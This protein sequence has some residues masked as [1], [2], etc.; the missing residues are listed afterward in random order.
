[1][2]H[3]YAFPR[4]ENCQVEPRDIPCTILRGGYNNRSYEDADAWRLFLCGKVNKKI[5]G[6][7]KK[8]SRTGKQGADAGETF[9]GTQAF[10]S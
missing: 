8:R 9:F 5:A 6:F 1:M 10:F 4:R 7:Q 2:M 3:L